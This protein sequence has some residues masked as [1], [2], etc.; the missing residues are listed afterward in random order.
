MVTDGISAT[1]EFTGVLGTDG[2]VYFSRYRND[3][4]NI[5]GGFV[6]GGRDYLRCGGQICTTDRVS[7]KIVYD[8]LGTIIDTLA[9]TEP[10]L[11]EHLT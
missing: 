6:D 10:K 2:T 3:F 9:N 7:L 8:R 11:L 1:E 4:R 5:P